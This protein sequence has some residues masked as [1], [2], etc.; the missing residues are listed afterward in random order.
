MA[1]KDFS[2][3]I[4]NG[5]LTAILGPNGSG[6]TT[7][8]KIVATQIQASSGNLKILG[9]D[10]RKNALEIKAKVGYAG[11]QSFLYNELTV[12]ENLRFY[13]SIF[14]AKNPTRR[15]DIDELIGFL[16]FFDWLETPVRNLSHGLRKRVDIARAM[17]HNPDLLLLDEPFSGL[18]EKS[19]MILV[20][21]LS[22]QGESTIVLSSHQVDLAKRLCNHLIFLEKGEMVREGIS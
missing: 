14:S 9:L 17:I 1:L 20:D 6:K 11:H 12:S 22:R 15:N 13:Q 2:A 3:K 16:G 10:P 21:Y 5:R 18:D 19:R 4:E 8:L 7:L